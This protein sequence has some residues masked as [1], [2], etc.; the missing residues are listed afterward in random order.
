MYENIRL[1]LLSVL[2]NNIGTKEEEYML[3]FKEN[4][5]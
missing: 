5:D 4:T 3:A 1:D 2:K